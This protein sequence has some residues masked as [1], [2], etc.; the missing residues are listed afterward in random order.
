MT[1]HREELAEQFFSGNGATYDQI[2]SFSTLGLD[3]WW[4]RKIL[5]KIPKTSN[6]II[7]QASGTGILTCKIARL[8]P[9]CRIIGVELH[10]EYLNIA[11]KKARD[12][13]LTNVE[14]IHGRAEDVVLDGEFDCI[15][16][17]YLAKYVDLDL[18]VAHA[19]KMLREGGVLIMH[20]LARPTNL[21]FMGLW[22]M[23]FKFLQ[24]Y[25]KWKYPEWGVAFRD[26]PLLLTRTQW[27][28][29]LTRTL[30]AN[31]FLDIK[32]E[33]LLFGASVIVSARK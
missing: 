32:V 10:E 33:Y 22:K 12:L 14:F 5:N 26:V 6:R 31:K 7:E 15:A 8:F 11:R 3:G 13:Q 2:A 4:K 19:R 21:L 29:E 25:G 28:D 30:R 16:S 23:H 18:L 27:V 9:K 17:A 24:T 1:K 20:E